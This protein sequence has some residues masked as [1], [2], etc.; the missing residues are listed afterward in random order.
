MQTRRPGLSTLSIPAHRQDLSICRLPSCRKPALARSILLEKLIELK[1][2]SGMTASD[3]LKDLADVQELIKLKGLDAEFAS[4]LNEF[5][6]AKYIE[7]YEAVAAAKN[8]NRE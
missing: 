8:R 2:A 4:K 1:L 3:R 6:R 7:L 5:V